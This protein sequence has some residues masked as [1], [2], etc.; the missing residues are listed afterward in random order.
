M[1]VISLKTFPY[2]A[3]TVRA[4]YISAIAI[5]G[6]TTIS[7]VSQSEKDFEAQNGFKR[8]DYF[9]DK[10]RKYVPAAARKHGYINSDESTV[11]ASMK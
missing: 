7:C 2:I 9:G 5:T 4:I 3:H 10:N 11:G 1:K 8:S 6:F